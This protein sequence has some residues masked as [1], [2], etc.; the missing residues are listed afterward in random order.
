M[1]ALLDPLKLVAAEKRFV[2][3]DV[4]WET[5]QQLL[6]DYQDRSTPRLT[7]VFA[8]DVTRHVNDSFTTKQPPWLRKVREWI[9]SIA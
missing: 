3:H 7:Y 1:T 5:Y 9:R 8:A 2:L 6:S 4:S